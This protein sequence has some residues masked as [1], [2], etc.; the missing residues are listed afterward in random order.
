LITELIDAV[1]QW[2]DQNREEQL[3]SF[4]RKV[5]LGEL[6]SVRELLNAF[7]S[8]YVRLIETET[9]GLSAVRFIAY[10]ELEQDPNAW[11][12]QYKRT[13]AVAIRLL[14]LLQAANPSAEPRDLRRRTL[15]FINAVIFGFAGHKHLKISFFGDARPKSLSELGRLYI[16]YG[17]RLLSG[18]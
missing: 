9:W 18:T 17:E 13:S 5:A 6:V 11:R 2:F 8:P 4:E 7:V 15:F 10:I 1:Q 14:N 12:A 16:R 3:A